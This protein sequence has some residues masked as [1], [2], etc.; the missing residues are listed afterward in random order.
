M[1]LVDPPRKT[2]CKLFSNGKCCVVQ[3]FVNNRR[4]QCVEV[5]FVVFWR[6]IRMGLGVVLTHVCLAGRFET[7]LRE[8]VHV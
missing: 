2:S 7:G 4:V 6:V 8:G 5:Y 1:S 3:E